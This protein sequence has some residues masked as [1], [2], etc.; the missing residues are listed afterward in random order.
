[1]AVL[2]L[3]RA[4]AVG[5][6]DLVDVLRAQAVLGLDLL[7]VLAGVD[8]EDVVGVLPA[9]LEHE[10]AR[11]DGRAVEDVGREADD[12]IEDVFRL[13][14]VLAD[15]LLGRAAK[16]DAV[17][18]DGRHGAA[19]GHLVEHVLHEGEVGLGL[20]REAPVVGE[21]LVAEEEV[22]GRPLGGKGRVGDDGVEAVVEVLGALEGVLVFD[23][24]LLEVDAV[25]DEVH[26]AQVVGGRR[27]LL[28]EEGAHLFHFLGHA[29]QQG[30]GTAGGVVDAAQAGLA[31]GDNLG[32]D[33]RDF[34]RGVEFA[35]LLAGIA[36]ELSDEVFVGVA[37]DV[38]LGVFEAEVDLLEVGHDLD[39]ERVFVVFGPAQLAAGEVEVFKEVA[40]VF[41]ALRAHG[42]LL[43]AA[44]HLLKVVENEL[45]A[46]SGIAPLNE[47]A[48]QL[49][50]LE[51]VA[52]G[53]QCGIAD[54]L[55]VGLARLG[56]LVDVVVG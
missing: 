40:E 23:V 51:E 20:G 1:M 14:Q 36:G 39:H 4:L 3:G 18:E 56:G 41:L 22:A 38:A 21:A 16:Q 10:D 52:Q 44:Q 50:R 11:R 55:K 13:D 6:D 15:V 54:G 5:V 7:E 24:E 31:G 45:L 48:K 30:A 37:E 17:G 43:N 8:E 53:L 19:V 47:A 29:E 35:R 26:A 34:L 2:V 46:A 32:E 12:R 49:G 33:G 27:H 25:H 42:A 9:L 28:A